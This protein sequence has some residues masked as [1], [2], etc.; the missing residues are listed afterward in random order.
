MCLRFARG[1]G[2]WFVVAAACEVFAAALFL[3]FTDNMAVGSLFVIVT[4]AVV[5]IIRFFRDPERSIGEGVIAAADG[6]VTEVEKTD[7]PDVGEST[8]R[9][10]TFMNVHNVH[11]NRSPLAGTVLSTTHIVGAHTPA[12]NKDS[13]RNE[14]QITV[15]E[16]EIG[17]IKL[18]QI[19]GTV[20]RRIVPYTKEGSRL[21][22][23]DRFGII[24]FGSRVDLYL[25]GRRVE[26]VVKVGDKVKAGESTVAKI[27]TGSESLDGE[28]EDEDDTK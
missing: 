15:L 24:L 16:T 19:A 7:D 21:E 27:V 20:A 17:K 25:P 9:I 6:K 26:V 22:K 28:N 12:F 18:V 8:I 11:V 5:V 14:R 23:G 1:S 3:S 4:L 2:I 10:A 13:D